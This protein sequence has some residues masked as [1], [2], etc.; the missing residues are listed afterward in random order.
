MNQ[1]TLLNTRPAHQAKALSKMILAHNGQVIHCP[2]IEIQWC[3]FENT[4][5]DLYQCTD[6]IIFISANAVKGF[7]KS[8]LYQRYLTSLKT[9][10]KPI[11]W[12]AIGQATQQSGLAHQLPLTVLSQTDFDS[13]TL[14]AHSVMQQIKQQSIVIVKGQGGRTLLESTLQARGAKVHLCEVYRRVPALFC[15]QN[16]QRFML[17][18]NPVLLLTSV[19]SFNYLL[20][21]LIQFDSDYAEL[22]NPKWTFLTETVVFSERIKKQMQAQGWQGSIQIVSTQSNAGIIDMLSSYS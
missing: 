10:T 2:T 3:A 8:V 21:N 18:R 6:K 16:W 22:N 17:S 1:F 12:Y 19:E 20:K 7:L 4:G 11:E 9:A 5:F 13:E 14:L 15:A